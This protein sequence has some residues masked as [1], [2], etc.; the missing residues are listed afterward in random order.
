MDTNYAALLTALCFLIGTVMEV[1]LYGQR[2]FH[3]V[4]HYSYS[5]W[6]LAKTL[7]LMV[8]PEL[9]VFMHVEGMHNFALFN[10]ACK[11]GIVC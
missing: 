11:C 4:Q 9:P 6:I 3:K 1:F 7:T 5:K 8:P 10:H 2:H